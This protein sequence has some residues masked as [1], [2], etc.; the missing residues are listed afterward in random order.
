MGSRTPAVSRRVILVDTPVWIDHI[1]RPIGPLCELLEVNQIE[2]HPFVIGEISLGNIGR[3]FLAELKRLPLVISASHDEVMSLIDRASLAGSGVGYVDA[4][5]LASTRLT[6]GRLLWTRD[7]RVR[8]V[9]E[10]LSI[11][12]GLD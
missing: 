1:R 4:H 8:A 9:A 2:V 6:T 11:D 5:L 12:A 7:R 10:R 3:D